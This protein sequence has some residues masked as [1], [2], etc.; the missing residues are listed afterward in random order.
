MEKHLQI[1]FQ[2][3]LIFLLKSNKLK[4]RSVHFLRFKKSSMNYK[5]VLF[6]L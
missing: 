2:K 1:H 6:Y 3:K 4:Q 5:E